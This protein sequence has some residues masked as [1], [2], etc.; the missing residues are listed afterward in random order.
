MHIN[1]EGHYYE[2][3]LERDHIHMACLRGGKIAEFV[4]DSFEKLKQ[5][6]EKDCRFRVLISRPEIGG[7]CAA[8]RGS[9]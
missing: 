9:K 4:S 6:V 1:G 8:C 2:R 7:Y 3:K 5:Q